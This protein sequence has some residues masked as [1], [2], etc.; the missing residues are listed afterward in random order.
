MNKKYIYCRYNYYLSDSLVNPNAN[1]NRES[2]AIVGGV[3]VSWSMAT[4]GPS[5]ALTH[6]LHHVSLAVSQWLSGGCLEVVGG[7]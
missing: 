6:C 4:F 1:R 2:W 5:D 7:Y 3:V